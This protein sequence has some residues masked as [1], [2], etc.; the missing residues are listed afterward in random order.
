MTTLQQG[1]E[2]GRARKKVEKHLSTFQE[3]SECNTEGQ[4]IA[5]IAGT[6]TFTVVAASDQACTLRVEE[7]KDGDDEEQT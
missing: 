3:S 5:L 6:E 7:E 4:N 1:V 2:Q